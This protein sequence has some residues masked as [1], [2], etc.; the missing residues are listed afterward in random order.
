M[1]STTSN[2]NQTG[3]ITDRNDIN[4]NPKLDPYNEEYSD[5]NYID[6]VYVGGAL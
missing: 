4:Y 2:S 6:G 5:P 3:I 1:Q